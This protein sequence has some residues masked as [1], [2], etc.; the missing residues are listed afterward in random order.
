MKVPFNGKMGKP[1]KF[2]HENSTLS[3]NNMQRGLPFGCVE[4]LYWQTKA[5]IVH[6]TIRTMTKKTFSIHCRRPH[7]T[8]Y[9]TTAIPKVRI[10]HVLFTVNDFQKPAI[11]TWIQFPQKLS[12]DWSWRSLP[13]RRLYRISQ[14]DTIRE[15]FPTVTGWQ[16]WKIRS[17]SKIMISSLRDD[18]KM[19]ERKRQTDK[20][21]DIARK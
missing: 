10:Y 7:R 17:Q 2:I 18:I 8:I 9:I 3:K 14:L 5:H 1:I 4:Y 16:L 11:H 15:Q 6:C 12:W 20:N 19:L 13:L 21:L